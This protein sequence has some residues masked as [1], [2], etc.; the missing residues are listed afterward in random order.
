MASNANP[1]SARPISAAPQPAGGGLAEIKRSF[2]LSTGLWGRYD[3]VLLDPCTRAELEKEAV[4][5]W[6]LLG[7]GA[8]QALLLCLVGHYLVGSH[9][10]LAII[11]ISS[12]V[13]GYLTLLDAFVMLHSSQAADGLTD[14]RA[15]GLR[16]VY[17]DIGRFGS[18]LPGNRV[19]LSLAMGTL[20]ALLGGMMTNAEVI[21]ARIEADYLARNRPMVERVLKTDVSARQVLADAYNAKSQ[22]VKTLT[23]QVT[24]LQSRL[25]R[26]S[27]RALSAKVTAPVAKLRK[28][29]SSR[30]SALA[31]ANKE[32]D[33]ARSKLEGW[34]A[35]R[36]AR[37]DQKIEA[38]PERVPKAKS[39]ES[40]LVAYFEEIQEHPRAAVPIWN[41]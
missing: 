33:A 36:N 19:L 28:D 35:D 16:L 5:G 4:R 38:S 13:A 23:E 7:N 37:V 11:L 40:R 26:L 21:D 14:L 12:F 17:P 30:E 9:F 34:D 15:G 41:S 18:L 39:L 32:L 10:N 20:V 8:I 24:Q 29:L 31:E 25:A 22:I 1:T 3:P 2:L 27:G 6:L